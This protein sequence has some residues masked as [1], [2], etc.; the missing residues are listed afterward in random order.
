MT[1]GLDLAQLLVETASRLP[2][3]ASVVAIL[4]TVTDEAA[5]ALGNLRRRGFAVTAIVNT[6]ED[7]DY[8]EAAGK[9]LAEQV[10]TRHLKDELAVSEICRMH[11]LR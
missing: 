9:L 8:A 1:D 7:R 2:R 4:S 3:D 11:A 6:Y 10:D 5:V